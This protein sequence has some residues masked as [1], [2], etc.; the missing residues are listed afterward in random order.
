MVLALPSDQAPG[1]VHGISSALD[2]AR[3]QIEDADIATETADLVRNQILQ[4]A[5]IAVMGQANLNSNVVLGLLQNL[6]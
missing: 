2:Q 3:S 5:Q 1:R 6:K 4:Q